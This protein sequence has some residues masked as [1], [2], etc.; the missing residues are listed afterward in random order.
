LWAHEHEETAI[1]LRERTG[2]R[3]LGL[4][5][6]VLS[7]VLFSVMSLGIRLAE[8]ADS[9]LTSFIR[10]AVGAAVVGS[11]AFAGKVQLS[12]V[13]KPL[14]LLRGLAGAA[15][16]Y[17]SFLAI[18]KLG[19]ARGSVLSYTFPLFAAIGGAIFLKERVHPLGWAALVASIGGV[20]LMR[21]GQLAADGPATASTALWYGLT[22]AGSV[23]AGLAIVCVRRLTVTDSAPAIFMGQ[24]LVGFWMTLVPAASRPAAFG[25]ALALLLLGIGLSASAAQ[26]L[27][28]WSYNHLDVATGSLLSML[29]P[30]INVALGVL[31]FREPFGPVE[32]VGAAIVV[33][34]CAA[35]MVPGRPAPAP[36]LPSRRQ[37]S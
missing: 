19:I 23:C 3:A 30:V 24:S 37:S 5:A 15:A 25:L 2:G 7:S 17:T 33:A 12:F 27:M 1:P 36:G 26:L 32:A 18:E 22:L 34:A 11:L 10:F 28:T 8:G 29:T 14:H 9:F 35:V 21:W 20:A 31:V 16:V 4:A 13:N 6:M